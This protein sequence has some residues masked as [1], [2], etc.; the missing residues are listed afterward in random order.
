MLVH[1]YA[2]LEAGGPLQPY[3][4]ESG[5]LG[6][7]EVDVRVTHG[8]ICHTDLGVIDDEFGLGRFPAVAG[9]EAVGV[10]HAVGDAVE[11]SV[12]RVGQRV[13]VG[14]ISGSCFHCEWC[15]S[16]Q[17]NLCPAR[18]DTVVRGDRGAFASHVRAS[19]WRHVHP[20]PDAIPSAQAAP[21]LCAGT[22]VFSPLLVNGVLPTH[23]VA[24]V[25]VGGLGHLAV[26]FLAKWGCEVTA[27]SRTDDKRADAERFGATGF[28]A[29]GEEGAIGAAAGTFDFVLSTVSANLPWDDYVGLLRPQGKL[30]VVGVPDRPITL[31]PMSLLPSA[32][33]VM[34]G[35][36]G[37]AAHTRQMLDFAARH[38]IRAEVETFGVAD[39]EKAL[40]RVRE[41]SARYRA[42]VE[43]G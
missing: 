1:A 2:A 18:D 37:S 35:I 8:G 15:L 42:V 5:P 27:I 25:G 17:T 24:V 33:Q 3:E 12:L 7:N 29:S 11:K 20:I 26:Q 16:G 32:K 6:A 14:A 40:G 43:F 38:D 13:G 21:L 41:G 22:T 39:F 19:D 31:S 4:Y 30:C 9:H 34:G 23:R 28:L 10:V 36:V